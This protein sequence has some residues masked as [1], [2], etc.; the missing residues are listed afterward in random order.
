MRT[1]L[2]GVVLCTLS[3]WA[4][5]AAAQAPAALGLAD[6][7]ALAEQ[8]NPA[9]A[10]ARQ[11]VSAAEARVAL[12]RAGR[13]PTVTA[14]TTPA[15]SSGT[16][17]APEGFSASAAV[18][19]TYVL[20]DSG[21]IAHAVRQAQATLKAARLALE[22]TRQDVA[23][24]VAQA[25]VGVLRAE[26]AVRVRE[27]VVVQ[28]RELLR[29]A[30]GQFRAGVVARADV[31]RAQANLAAAEGELIAARNAVDQAKAGLNAAIGQ[32][33]VVPLAVA[34]PP[35]TPRLTLAQ[36]A[37][38]PLAD[39]RPEVRR[40][41]AEVEAAEAGVALARAA[42][43]WRVTLD[44]RAAQNLTPSSSTT[45]SV[46]GSVSV[47]LSDA[48]R[49]AAAVAEAQATLAAARARVETARL[50]A[51]Q[52]S[53]QAFLNLLSARARIES[54]RA[55]LVFAQESLRL[56]QGRYAAGAGTLLEV[57]DAQT[58]LVQ[59]E[60]ALAGAEFDELAAALSLRHALGRS[61]VT[62]EI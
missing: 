25:Y 53:L 34:P 26:R 15:I 13:G 10:A 35:P 55:G 1:V 4:P 46:S 30:E 48:G 39:E 44:G 14:S 31:V 22:A 17:A 45:W 11:A 5:P 61:V 18:S 9:I 27:Q 57:T 43:G 52:Q 40:A 19:A 24:S 59:A 51:Q 38:A 33:A 20:Y 42:S 50:A 29:L 32:P 36:A 23:L 49:T 62:G 21:Q 12:A 6:V 47:P 7:V 2:L 8:R 56:A 60:Q 58:A 41:L 37:L 16:S 54:A 28:N 3:L